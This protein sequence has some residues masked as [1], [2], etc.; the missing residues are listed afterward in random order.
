MPS[1]TEYLTANRFVLEIDGMQVTIKSV[2]GVKSVTQTTDNTIIGN[3]GPGKRVDQSIPSVP[4]KGTLSITIYVE[5]KNKK[6][7]EWLQK[8]SSNAG[9]N[10]VMSNIK[11]GSL[12][13]YISDTS[14]GAKWELKQ[15]YPTSQTF[16]GFDASG[17]GFMTQQIELTYWGGTQRKQ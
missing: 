13:S 3:M 17:T 8:C 6:F 4:E 2:D 9:A 15:C 10:K 14:I 1:N 12:V 7:D 11:S 16:T 5:D